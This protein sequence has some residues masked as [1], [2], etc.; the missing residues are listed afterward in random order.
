MLLAIS[1]SLFF[2]TNP[3]NLGIIRCL[4]VKLFLN[5]KDSYSF[6]GYL[7]YGGYYPCITGN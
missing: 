6:G 5:T 7:L 4:V 2:I 1:S 3:I